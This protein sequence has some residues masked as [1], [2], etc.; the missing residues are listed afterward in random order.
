[1]TI[2]TSSPLRNAGVDLLEEVQKLGAAVAF[3]AF[4]YDEAGG[5]VERGEQRNRAVA[6]IGVV[7][8]FR[9]AG[10]HRQDRLLSPAPGSGPSHRR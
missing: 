4:S 8:A 9:N 6:D 7:P 10:H 2:W 3:V 1:M 5:D